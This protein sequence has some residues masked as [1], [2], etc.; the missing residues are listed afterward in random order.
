MILDK[1]ALLSKTVGSTREYT[2]VV[3]STA[4]VILAE[5]IRRKIRTW[6]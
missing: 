5:A 2:Y 6:A 3:G 1:F 4:A